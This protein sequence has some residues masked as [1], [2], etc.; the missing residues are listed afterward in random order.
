M[1]MTVFIVQYVTNS[2]GMFSFDELNTRL[3]KTKEET[4]T[5]ILE[6]AKREYPHANPDVFADI[7]MF[8]DYLD[9]LANDHKPVLMYTISEISFRI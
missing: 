2:Y 3:F 6:I 8:D 4:R 5:F 1:P 9:R 7:E